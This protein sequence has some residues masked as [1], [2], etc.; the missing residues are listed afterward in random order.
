VLEPFFVDTLVVLA[1]P[2]TQLVHE[3]MDGSKTVMLGEID[4]A[5]LKMQLS[6]RGQL[7]ITSYDNLAQHRTK[8]SSIKSKGVNIVV[9]FDEVCAKYQHNPSLRLLRNTFF[10]SRYILCSTTSENL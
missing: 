8:L 5:T 4:A 10:L 2:F 3:A 7:A 6:D 9:V 1:C